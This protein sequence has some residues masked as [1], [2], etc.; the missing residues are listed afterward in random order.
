M[1]AELRQLRSFTVLAE[2]GS[3]RKAA[4]R[5]G[6]TQPALTR[7][8]RDLEQQLGFE[9]FHRLPRGVELTP[10]G[11]LYLSK[12]RDILAR[13]GE[14]KQ[15]AA[16]TA[17]GEAG[18]LHL[19]FTDPAARDP[20]VIESFRLFRISYPHVDL[21]L[22]LMRSSAQVGSILAAD[23]DAGFMFYRPS[24]DNPFGSLKVRD[25]EVKLVLPADHELA[26]E[27]ELSLVRVADQPLI[28]TNRDL[29]TWLF[30][31]LM[32]YITPIQPFPKIVQQVS[33]EHVILRLVSIGFGLSFLQGDTAELSVP[34]VVFRGLC[35]MRIETPLELVWNRGNVSPQLSNY[36]RIVEVLAAEGAKATR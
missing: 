7:Q 8:I 36:L 5:V 30:D 25:N 31:E 33:S 20:I 10:A 14:A 11:S 32:R 17:S 6:L 4:E 1:A 21:R 18:P 35:D 15:L 16:Q 22:T 23:V 13:L 27:P 29:N 24:Q 3:F 12:V 19:T 2:L 34:N 26:S 28:L 9:L